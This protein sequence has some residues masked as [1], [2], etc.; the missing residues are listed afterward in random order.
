MRKKNHPVS[1]FGRILFAVAHECTMIE[2]VLN[3]GPA[4]IAI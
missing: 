1:F 3:G 4:G 2:I